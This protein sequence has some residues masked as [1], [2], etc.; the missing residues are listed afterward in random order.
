MVYQLLLQDGTKVGQYSANS[1]PGK[2]GE[3]IAKQI[4]KDGNFTGKKEFTFEFVKNRIHLGT[5]DEKIYRF[6]AI[7]R[8]LPRTKENLIVTPQGNQFY[9]KYDIQ[10]QNLMRQ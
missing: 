7:V 5:N 8:P 10:V 2:V 9:K 3:K 6:R 4:Y 1:S